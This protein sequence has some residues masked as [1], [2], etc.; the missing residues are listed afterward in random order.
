M[1]RTANSEWKSAI[2]LE[3]GEKIQFLSQ[4]FKY[5]IKGTLVDKKY[6]AI[7]PK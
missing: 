3:I 1:V 5:I 6:I 4:N 7:S 2:Q